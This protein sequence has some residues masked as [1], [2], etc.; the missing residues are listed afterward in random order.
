MK[1]FLL[2][3][4]V[5]TPLFGKGQ[6]AVPALDELYAE[7]YS[8]IRADTVFQQHLGPERC[9][10]VFDSLIYQSPTSFSEILAKRWGYIG[11]GKMSRLLDSLN[12]LDKLGYHKPYF[13]SQVARLTP[14]SGAA[15]GCMVILFSRVNN[16]MLLAEVSDN[17]EGGPGVRNVLSTFDQSIHYLFLLGADGKIE[18]YHTQFISYN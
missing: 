18:R 13:S 4:M 3:I 14:V 8:H 17:Q 5:L 15:K 12:T 2:V 7:A 9:V 16:G 1:L 6:T 11:Y 10:A